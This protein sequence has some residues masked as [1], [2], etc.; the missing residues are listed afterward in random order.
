[1]CISEHSVSRDS[2]HHRSHVYREGDKLSA[3]MQCTHRM[4]KGTVEP[5]AREGKLADATT[6]LRAASYHPSFMCNHEALERGQ[7]HVLI[8]WCVANCAES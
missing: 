5:I 1:M 2:L 7:Q 3:N 4:G 6:N 8:T